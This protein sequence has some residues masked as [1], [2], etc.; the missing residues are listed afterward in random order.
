MFEEKSG[1]LMWRERRTTVSQSSPEIIV[2]G[3]CAEKEGRRN[4]G[5]K[6][7]T[8]LPRPKFWKN[9]CQP[10]EMIKKKI[11]GF[12]QLF[13]L[14]AA[15]K[16]KESYDYILPHSIFKFIVHAYPSSGLYGTKLLIFFRVSYN[17]IGCIRIII[18]RCTEGRPITLKNKKKNSK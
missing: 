10:K 2:H 7:S 16:L 11:S 18:S 17:T 6:V 3:E 8:K 4:D 13:E 14:D 15:L 1:M 5:T 12:H 9:R